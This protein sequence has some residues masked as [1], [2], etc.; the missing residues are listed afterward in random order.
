LFLEAIT[1]VLFLGGGGGLCPKK[2]LTGC[3][4]AKKFNF[5]PPPL[6]K[7]YRDVFWER[8]SILAKYIA[9]GRKMFEIYHIFS[10]MLFV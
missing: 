3:A 5:G 6:E 1:L 9:I 10:V 8:V 2:K 7:I 4:C